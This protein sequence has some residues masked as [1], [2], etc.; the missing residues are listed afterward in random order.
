MAAG[1]SLNSET[2][3]LPSAALAACTLRVARLAD[4]AAIAAI[5]APYVQGETTSFELDA[6]S[7]EEMGQRVDQTLYT[8]PWLVAE[9]DGEVIGYAYACEHR[10][11]LA[12]QWSV[13]V[14]VYLHREARRQGTGR[15]LYSRLFAILCRQGFIN[16]YAG[17]TLPNEGS[18][19]L[20]E[21]MGFWPVGV[22]RGVGHKFGA[23]RD[24]GWWQLQ[25]QPWPERPVPPE[26]FANVAPLL[27]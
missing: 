5:Y 8:H 10:K 15:R 1:I 19:G 7:V 14:A 20:H 17:I 11:R 3:L 25:L 23:P 9:R 2:Q 13:D 22:Y 26:P 6:P 16:A 27:G 21:A 4:A 24:V 18:V 12:Y